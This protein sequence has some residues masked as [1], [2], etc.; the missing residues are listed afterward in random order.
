MAGKAFGDLVAE[1]QF[2]VV[3]RGPTRQ[4]RDP[5]RRRGAGQASAGRSKNSALTRCGRG[6]FLDGL[7]TTAVPD[8]AGRD[9]RRASDTPSPPPPRWL[10]RSIRPRRAGR[11]PPGARPTRQGVEHAAVTRCRAVPAVFSSAAAAAAPGRSRA[12]RR[13]R[14][15]PGSPIRR[16]SAAFPRVRRAPVE[17]LRRTAPRAERR[18]SPAR[19]VPGRTGPCWPGRW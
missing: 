11:R 15:S 1:P 10:I 16:D 17:I 4:T 19:C 9:D 6:L 18:G 3:A 2:E 8:G 5:V 7:H 14:R 13:Q 12:D